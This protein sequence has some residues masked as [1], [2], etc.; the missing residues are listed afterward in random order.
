MAVGVAEAVTFRV[1]R[2][3]DDRYIEALS[4]GAFVEYARNAAR[5]VRQLIR[6]DDALTELAV[7]DGEPV[8]FVIVS[9][10]RTRSV[11]ARMG[12]PWVAHLSAIATDPMM[13]RRGIARQLVGRA[14]QMARDRAALCLSLT[15]GVTNVRARTLFHTAGF[16]SLA[17]VAD[18]YRPGQDAV[19]MHKPL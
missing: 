6:G 18:F 15:T 8:G 13:L 9:F 14:E 16:R 17:G 19:F 12:R 4:A 11:F 5:A 7:A 2:P 10:A 1:R 3:G